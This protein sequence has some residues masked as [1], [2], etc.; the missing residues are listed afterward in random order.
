MWSTI[1]WILGW[2]GWVGDYDDGHPS[3]HT[4]GYGEVGGGG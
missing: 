2:F 1:G 3:F 4:M